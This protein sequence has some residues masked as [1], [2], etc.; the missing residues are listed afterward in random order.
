[1][2][3]A[4]ATAYTALFMVGMAQMLPNEES[5]VPFIGLEGPEADACPGIGRINGLEPRKGD[6]LRVRSAAD[7]SAPTTHELTVS[8]LVWLCEADEDW[9]GIVFPKGQFQDLGDCQ[10]STAMAA[11]EQY[12]GPCQSGWIKAKYVE[13]VTG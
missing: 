1:M 5:R 3:W 7:E 8:T 12:Q 9:Q 10:V 2:V 13:L 6:L 11:P 4:A